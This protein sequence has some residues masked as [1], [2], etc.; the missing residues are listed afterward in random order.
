MLLNWFGVSPLETEDTGGAFQ[1]VDCV[2][3]QVRGVRKMETIRT[4][5]VGRQAFPE[6][7]ASCGGPDVA[8]AEPGW[9]C[10]SA[11]AGPIV[12]HD[13]STGLTDI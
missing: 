12:A 8:K 7:K 4:D 2:V 6:P 1:P 5:I 10:I 3:A 9:W 13:L 11:T